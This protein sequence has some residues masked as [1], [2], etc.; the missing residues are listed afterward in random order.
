MHEI[1]LK[2]I[3]VYISQIYLNYKTSLYIFSHT[4][5][6]VFMNTNMMMWYDDDDDDDD[7]D[8]GHHQLA[9]Y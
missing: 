2:W 5:A 8:D 1:I 3:F 6:E 7:D 9:R 4:D